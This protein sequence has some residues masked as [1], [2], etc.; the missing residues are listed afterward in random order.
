MKKTI[1]LLISL[2][3]LSSCG[4]GNAQESH[5]GLFPGGN[6]SS[7]V[8]VEHIT[9]TFQ[10]NGGETLSP[11]TDRIENER[12][13]TPTRLG[14][15][16]QGWYE[17]ETF[18]GEPITY[19]YVPGKDVTLYAKWISLTEY[20]EQMLD[21]VCPIVFSETGD[22]N[23]EMK[24]EKIESSQY[25]ISYDYSIP[26]VGMSVYIDYKFTFGNF[27]NGAGQL[28]SKTRHSTIKDTYQVSK[29][30]DTYQF[31]YGPSLQ[32]EEKKL[33]NDTFKSFI[34]TFDAAVYERCGFYLTH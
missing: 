18:E 4:G 16:F 13:V 5:S 12:S 9:I 17:S 22:I 8:S 23:T 19:P 31:T 25:R 29:T 6:A 32:A 3:A 27:G 20:N 21:L 34:K 14:Y 10:T 26:Q 15:V 11:R 24:L 2:L 28:E 30:L 33:I 1:P 7:E